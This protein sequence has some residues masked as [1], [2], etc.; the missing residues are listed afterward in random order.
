MRARLLAGNGGGVGTRLALVM[1]AARLVV[2]GCGGN[3]VS[4]TPGKPSSDSD[5]LQSAKPTSP[6]AVS[7]PD[8]RSNAAARL[9]HGH[10]IHGLGPGGRRSHVVA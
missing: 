8:A 5:V 10:W 6:G 7:D 1:P 3:P 2:A 9:V 4:P